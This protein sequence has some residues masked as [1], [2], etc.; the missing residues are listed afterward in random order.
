MLHETTV[1]QSRTKHIWA[2]AFPL[3]NTDGQRWAQ[4]KYLEFHLVPELK[5]QQQNN[6]L[7]LTMHILSVAP[8]ALM[9][10]G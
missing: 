10:W 5:G 7:S 8:Q 6:T 3:Q 2:V 9:F 1:L 4:P